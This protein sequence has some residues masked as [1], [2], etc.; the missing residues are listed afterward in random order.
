MAWIWYLSSLSSDV[1]SDQAGWTG[2]LLAW[3]ETFGLPGDKI[4]HFG[5]Y[6]ILGLSWNLA[7]NTHPYRIWG[8]CLVYGIIDEIH[9]SFV[10]GRSPDGW[11]VLVD[12]IGAAI[13][14]HPLWFSW[15]SPSNA[16][17]KTQGV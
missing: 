5:I 16:K 12:T 2:S 3:L 14:C 4:A 15:I 7:C 11:D 13:G 10:P 6:A 9:Q 8:I 17:S 1:I